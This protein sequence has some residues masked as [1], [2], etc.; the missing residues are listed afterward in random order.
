M[1]SVKVI[2]RSKANKKGEHPL[3]LQ[4]IKD[5]KS[6]II[7]LGHHILEK[8]WDE[9]KQRVKKSHPNSGRLNAYIGKRLTEATEKLLE[10]QSAG[11]DNSARTIR[12]VVKSGT[13]VGLV[14]GV[15]G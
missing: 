5:R 6:S 12:K 10:L 2:L 13:K 8:D 1:A 15:R 11:R 14:V 3:A 4:I 9:V 7:H